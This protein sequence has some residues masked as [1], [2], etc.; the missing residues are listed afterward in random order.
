MNNQVAPDTMPYLRLTS[1]TGKVWEFGERNEKEI[2]SGDAVGFAQV[3]TQTRSFYDVNLMAIG[4]VA[5]HWMNI[6][7][8]FAGKPEKPPIKGSRYIQ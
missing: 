5:K 1:P 6:A 3:V 7:Q 8:C 2:I 4:P